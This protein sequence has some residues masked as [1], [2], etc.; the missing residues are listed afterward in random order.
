MSPMNEDRRLIKI[1]KHP[2]TLT[3]YRIASAP[4]IVVL[5]ILLALPVKDSFRR[6][7]ADMLERIGNHEFI[8]QTAD[9]KTLQEEGAVLVDLNDPQDFRDQHLPQ[10]VNLPS[11]ELNVEMIRGFFRESGTYVLHSEDLSLACQA[12]MIITGMGFDR[13]FVLMTGNADPQA[14]DAPDFI[15]VPDTS[16]GNQSRRIL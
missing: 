15:F 14:I 9:L 2:N 10:A 8:I 3:L 7:P 12:W 13:V 4:V 11:E 6:S 16:G 5:M 1:L